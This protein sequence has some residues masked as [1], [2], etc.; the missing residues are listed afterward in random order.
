[1]IQAG[2]WDIVKVLNLKRVI[3]K[4]HLDIVDQVDEQFPLPAPESLAFAAVEQGPNL[5]LSVL[6]VLL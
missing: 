1:M 5:I 6:N 4:V 3:L 2:L